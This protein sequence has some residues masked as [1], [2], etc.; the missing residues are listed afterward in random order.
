[1]K[2]HPNRN[3]RIWQADLISSLSQ[4]ECEVKFEKSDGSLRFM[5]CTLQ[6]NLVPVTKGTTK[7]KNKDCL[8]VFDTEAKG[9][10][11]IKFDRL[12]SYTVQNEYVRSLE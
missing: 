10:R 6:S 5:K 9:W 4:H 11:T 1:M 2:Y 12:I 7:S 8:T 3:D